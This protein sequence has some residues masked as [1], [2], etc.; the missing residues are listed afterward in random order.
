MYATLK[1]AGKEVELYDD[2][3]KYDKSLDEDVQT[4]STSS[5]ARFMLVIVS[6]P[7]ADVCRT[8]DK[9]EQYMC[10]NVREGSVEDE[11]KKLIRRLIEILDS[12]GTLFFRN[13]YYFLFHPQAP[14]TSCT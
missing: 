2:C 13:I 3:K 14:V 9:H 5:T 1:D 7:G 4:R 10:S 11:R 6:Q 12:Q 8:F